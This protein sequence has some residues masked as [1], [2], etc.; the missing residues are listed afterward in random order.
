MS[1]ELQLQKD[2][3]LRLN[4]YIE[5][6]VQELDEKAPA[7]QQLRRDYDLAE[8]NC[9]QLTQKLNAMFEEC[10]SLRLESEDTRR[11]ASADS[12]ENE[13]LK[14]L[15]SDLGRQVKVGRQMFF[16]C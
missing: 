15:C 1:E 7:L 13:R 6:I 9:S 12:R 11:H 2:E 5:Q 10:E 16:T 8:Q 4:N 3:N 14:Q